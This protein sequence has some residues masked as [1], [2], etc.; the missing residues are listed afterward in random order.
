MFSLSGLTLSTISVELYGLYDGTNFAETASIVGYLATLDYRG[1]GNKNSSDWNVGEDG[2]LY[3]PTLTGV[4]NIDG[5]TAFT[6]QCIRLGHYATVSGKIN[7]DPTA[8]A[9]LTQVGISLPFASNLTN[10]QDCAGTASA[11]AISECGAITAD[12][13]ND[14]AQLNFISAGTT[15][16]TIMYTFTYR[17]Q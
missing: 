6:S 3:T 12:T 5:V 4:S 14:R 7:V 2:I 11:S 1:R 13:T 17:I 16:H 9:T 8:G 10:E 15:D